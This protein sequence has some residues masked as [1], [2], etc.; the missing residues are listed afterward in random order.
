MFRDPMQILLS[1]PAV[2]LAIIFHELAHALMADKLGDMTPRNYGR[3][4]LNPLAHMDIIGLLLFL[5]IG[6]GWAKPVPINP[7][8][9]K[10]PKRDSILVS[11]AGPIANFFIAFIFILIEVLLLKVFPAA[12]NAIPGLIPVFHSIAYLNIA[13]GLLNLLPIPPLDG[14]H[15]VR[16]L[17]AGRFR[18]FFI[19]YERYSIIVFFVA[20]FFIFPTVFTFAQYIFLSV[21]RFLI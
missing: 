16:D 21:L 14:Y 5:F 10:N 2:L 13:F 18:D 11:I 17:L 15:I 1:V 19:M 20:L 6:F 7:N 4:T 3:L 9:F 12:Y 8:N